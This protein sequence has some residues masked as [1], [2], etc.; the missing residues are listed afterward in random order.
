M[1]SGCT[2]ASPAVTPPAPPSATPI[3]AQAG[4]STAAATP[5]QRPLPPLGA[6]ADYQLGGAYPP[7]AGVTVVTRDSSAE[8]AP[9]LYSICYVNGFQTQPGADWPTELLVTTTAG[10]P[11]TDPNWP[12]EHILDI[13][14]TA[15][16]TQIVERLT[17]TI[18]RCAAAGF[19]AVEFDNFDSFTRSDGAFTSAEAVGFATTLV[20]SAHSSGLAAAQKNAPDLARVGATSVGFD[21]AIAEECFQFSECAAYAAAYGHR[22]IDVEYADTLSSSFSTV[23]ASADRPAST[24]LRDRALTPAGDPKHIYEH[25]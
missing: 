8:P 25:C 23:C 10:E 13:S 9:G 18:Q 17:P 11:I 1:V 21:F 22:V 2:G 6:V 14:T 16:Q 3:P 19:A 20:T 12:D 24:M 5:G 15:K 7:D 4:P